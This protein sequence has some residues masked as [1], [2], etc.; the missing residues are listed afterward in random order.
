M[1]DLISVLVPVTDQNKKYPR[2]ILTVLTRSRNEAKFNKTN[3]IYGDGNKDERCTCPWPSEM[4]LNRL[5]ENPL[6]A[7][8][9]S[10]AMVGSAPGDRMK[11]SGAQQ[12]ESANDLV[13]SNGGGSTKFLPSFSVTKFVTAGM[14]CTCPV[15]RKTE[16]PVFHTL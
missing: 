14:T 5:P 13:R 6:S 2:L 15:N 3:N 7:A 16:Q 9:L 8:N 4:E 12:L 1:L 11:M 10:S